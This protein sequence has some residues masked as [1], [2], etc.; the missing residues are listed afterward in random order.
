MSKAPHQNAAALF[1]NWLLS[2]E[3]QIIS[4]K[5][6]GVQS[7]RVDVPTDFLLPARVRRPGVKYYSLIDEGSEAKKEESMKLAKEMYGH[8]MK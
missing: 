1:C 2:R 8:L 7:A 6:W 3:G 4:T 5:A